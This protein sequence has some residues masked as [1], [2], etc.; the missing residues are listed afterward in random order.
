MRDRIF[1]LMAPACAVMQLSN[2]NAGYLALFVRGNDYPHI[3][4]L[5]S[6]IHTKFFRFSA[7]LQLAVL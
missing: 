5:G 3:P 7:S 6:L 4:P 2:N 1:T